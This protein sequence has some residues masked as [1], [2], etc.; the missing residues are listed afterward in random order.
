MDREIHRG[1]QN[2]D[3][4]AAETQAWLNRVIDHLLT[5]RNIAVP[6]VVR[7]R[8]ALADLLFDRMTEHGR[9]QIRKAAQALFR[10]E[11]ERRL[12]T[13]FE[14]SFELLEQ[15][16]APSRPY[17]GTFEYRKR[18]FDLI[19]EMNDDEALC[20]KKIDDH[21]NV[22]RWLRNLSYE[23][24]GGYSLPLSPG[25][26]FPDFIVELE[27]WRTAIVEYKGPHLANN[28]K[29]LHKR[30]VGKLWADRSAGKCVFVWV[31]DHDWTTLD[32]QLAA[33]AR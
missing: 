31:V 3:I 1:G 12:E 2:W 22:R 7:K 5:E 10:N 32:T 20:A 4:T 33:V 23:S 28:P 18:A 27:D 26:F 24:A 29:E 15:D 21:P 11:T 17:R 9:A 16:Y 19:G 30:D 25:K 14:M 13:T 8:H 6:I